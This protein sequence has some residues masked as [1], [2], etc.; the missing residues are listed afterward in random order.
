MGK[1][2]KVIVEEPT[3][4]TE[5]NPLMGMLRR[6]ML[7]GMGAMALTQDEVEKLVN[8]FI[9]RGEIA[10]QDGKRL[11]RDV[12]E[13]RK[14]ETIKVEDQLDKRVEDLLARMNVPT[15]SDIDAL[16]AKITALGKKLDELKNP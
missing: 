4:Q 12:M 1:E 13:K 2:V 11:V 16:S 7:A 15:K 14:K 3:E 6:L 5:S 9:E 10:E 8:R